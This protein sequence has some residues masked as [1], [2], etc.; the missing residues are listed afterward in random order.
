MSNNVFDIFTGRQVIQKDPRVK[1][2]KTNSNRETRI[3]RA[4]FQSGGNPYRSEDDVFVCND[5]CG[6]VGD[7]EET[8]KRYTDHDTGVYVRCPKCTDSFGVYSCDPATGMLV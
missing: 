4:T 2:L 7:F 1:I 5:K 8:K 3:L 6:W